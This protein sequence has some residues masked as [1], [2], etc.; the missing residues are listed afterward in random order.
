M[1]WR[2]DSLERSLGDRLKQICQLDPLSVVDNIYDDP[3]DAEKR[4]KELS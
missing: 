4:I 1:P 3:N 2:K